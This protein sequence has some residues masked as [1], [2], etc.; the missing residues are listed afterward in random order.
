MLSPLGQDNPYFILLKVFTRVLN[1][2]QT[3]HLQCYEYLHT[4]KSCLSPYNATAYVDLV[5]LMPI[6][7]SETTNSY[8]KSCK[9]QN[10]QSVHS[11]EYIS[12]LTLQYTQFTY[13]CLSHTHIY[14]VRRVAERNPSEERCDETIHTQKIYNF[15]KA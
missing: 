7:D 1:I 3:L 13:V 11:N 6:L 8:C 2:N 10:K 12:L 5:K 4:Q 9:P 14:K 15:S